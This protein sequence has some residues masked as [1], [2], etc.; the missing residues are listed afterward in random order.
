MAK[1]VKK[2][3]KAVV[4]TSAPTNR[5]AALAKQA[6]ARLAA[7]VAANNTASAAGVSRTAKVAPK[8]EEM[9]VI[10]RPRT[11]KR[12][13]AT[14]VAENISTS[15]HEAVKFLVAGIPAIG[16]AAPAIVAA[17][18]QDGGSF[19]KSLSEWKRHFSFKQY[20]AAKG[21]CGRYA[22]HLERAGFNTTV[23]FA[24]DY[25]AYL[26]TMGVEASATTEHPPLK[27]YKPI[28]GWAA[29]MADITA[30]KLDAVGNQTQISGIGYFEEGGETIEKTF[31]IPAGHVVLPKEWD[32]KTGD[33]QEV[34]MPYWIANKFDLLAV[35]FTVSDKASGKQIER[36]TQK[37]DTY[38]KARSLGK[39]AKFA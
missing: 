9:E 6:K 8:E 11:R 29:M 31:S 1:I 17:S 30:V 20:V 18:E 12:E 32:F 27:Q 16:V 23:I 15:I 13:A 34:T 22:P 37:R 38:A 25:D 21:K 10:S 2:A 5:I 14:R 39:V 33:Y 4:K 24:A 26:K 19:L 28:V 7:K 36:L 35:C 3:A